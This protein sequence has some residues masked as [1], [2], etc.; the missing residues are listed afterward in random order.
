MQTG[1]YACGLFV[2][3]FVRELLAHWPPTEEELVC[4]FLFGL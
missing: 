3:Y 4:I 2:I 1:I